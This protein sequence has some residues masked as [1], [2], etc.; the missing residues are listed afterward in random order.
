MEA[1][2]TKELIIRD[3]VIED[4]NYFYEWELTSEVTEYFSIET[5]QSYETV[6]RTYI[7]DD[8]EQCKKQLT[9]V[10]KETGEP[11]GRI[12]LNDLIERWKVEVFR[13]YIGDP[14]LRGKGYGRQAMEA[15]MKLAFEEWEIER[16][17]LDHYLD[18]PAS[19]LYKSLGFKYEG[20]LRKSCRKNGKLYDV[21]LMSML[22]D[23][24]L[25]SY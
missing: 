1:L 12:V 16:M 8:E 14:S 6:V 2:V 3:S 22:R 20:V 25:N 4:I 19:H 7:H 10:L 24:Y 23:E 13:I 18:N 21:H 15:I 9:L 17:F 5:N 11:I